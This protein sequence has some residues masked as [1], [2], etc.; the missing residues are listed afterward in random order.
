MGTILILGL[1]ALVGLAFVG[2]LQVGGRALVLEKMATDDPPDRWP[3]L[4][5][6][7]PVAGAPPGLAE[8]L[9]TLLKQDYPDYEVIF[10][11][12]DLED[13]ATRVIAA[14]LPDHPHSRLVISGPARA[15]GQKNANLLGGLSLVGEEVEI[16]A[17]CDSNQEAAPDF[18]RRLAAPLVR[19][20]ARVASG[21][22]QILPGDQR[23]TTWSRAV[24]VLVL[25]LTKALPRLNQPWGG[26]TAIWRDLF[27]ALKVERLWAETVVDD[28]SLAAR[29][30][31][32]RIPVGV[33]FGATLITPVSGETWASFRNWLFRQW[34]YLKYY[35]PG[36]WLAAGLFVHLTA[37]LV[38]GCI[39]MLL[40][41]LVGGASPGS[42]GVALGFLGGLG[43]L[44]LKLRRFHPGA[45]SAG[46]WLGACI[47]ALLM[48][49]LVHGQTC[50][51]QRITWRHLTYQVNWQGKVV[52]VE[53]AAG[54]AAG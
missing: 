47:A 49:S 50:L 25:Y 53:K 13:P 33:S 1:M 31:R 17:F 32:A 42:L 14:L 52:S 22:H 15:C 38:L 48:A 2:L 28:V 46:L 9:L 19:G 40:L 21:Y 20:E 39:G 37:A 23:L 54:S 41:G 7:V 10:A 35:L 6:I 34:I 44:A 8:R 16:L 24:I 45:P 18:L 11:T 30:I 43:A 3:R 4:A 36:S 5:L 29:L 51:T 12:R 27:A 26:A